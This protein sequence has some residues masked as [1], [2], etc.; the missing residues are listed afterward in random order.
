MVR[1]KSLFVVFEVL[2][3]G[4]HFTVHKGRT[5]DMN[6]MWGCA[7]GGTAFQTS[8]TCQA[9]WH[10]YS[11]GMRQTAWAAW[12]ELTGAREALTPDPTPCKTSILTGAPRPNFS[13]ALSLLL[14]GHVNRG[15]SYSL[16]R[17]LML[18]QHYL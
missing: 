15:A 9:C 11:W 4:K 10:I 18:L 3:S 5:K 13:Q 6:D 12:W 2:R 1:P 17:E 16:P 8:T 14:V 7:G